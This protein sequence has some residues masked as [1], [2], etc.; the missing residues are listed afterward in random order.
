[1][2]DPLEEKSS[3]QEQLK[4]ASKDLPED[5]PADPAPEEPAPVMGEPLKTEPLKTASPKTEPPKKKGRPP[6][7]R[8]DVLCEQCGKL[9][10]VKPRHMF[11]SLPQDL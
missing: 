4:E 1:M 11:A 7:P 5:L 2:E 3:Y 6:R 8:N 10:V 9:I